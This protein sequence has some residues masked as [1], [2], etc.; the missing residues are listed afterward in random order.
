MCD[1]ESDEFTPKNASYWK[2]MAKRNEKCHE[3][4]KI[5]QTWAY[6]DKDHCDEKV[7]RKALN[8]TDVIKICNN[9]LS[10]WNK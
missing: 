1:C 10:R 8:F 5:I 9:A 3:A 6:F 7:S 4:I 2:R